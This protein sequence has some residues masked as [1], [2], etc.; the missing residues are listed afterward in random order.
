MIGFTVTDCWKLSL[1]HLLFSRLEG[2]HNAELTITINVFAG[3][4]TKQLIRKA[5]SYTQPL[6]NITM[7]LKYKDEA[8]VSDMSETVQEPKIKYYP[9]TTNSKGKTYTKSRRCVVCEKFSIAYC[10]CCNKTFCYAVGTTNYGCTCMTDHIK[11]MQRE[12]RRGRK[13]SSIV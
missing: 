12:G 9:S 8:D 10:G 4:L 5:V 3:I 6:E 7:N 2:K 11:K 1:H 13:R